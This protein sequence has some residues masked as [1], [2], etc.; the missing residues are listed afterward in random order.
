MKHVE[1]DRPDFGSF[2]P[3]GLMK[4]L[5]A[6]TRRCSPSW[7]G[8]RCAY[9]LRG[10]ALKLFRARPFD[11]FAINMKMR[12]YPY[13][14]TCEKRLLFMPQYFD[15]DELAYLAERICDDFV[16]IDIGANVGAYALYV[17]S[18]A[19]QRARILAVEPQPAIFERLVYNI[20]E[21]AFQ[22]VKAIDCAVADRPGEVTFFISP[23]NH[24]ES[25]MK[26][27]QADAHESSIR[28][29]AKTLQQLIEDE[30]FDHVDV[31]KIDAEGA[32]DLILES[33][34]GGASRSLWPKLMI[35]EHNPTDWSFDVEALLVE[36]GYR[37]VFR[38]RANRG[39][40]L[41]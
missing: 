35:L 6:A 38:T 2:A 17:A 4:L 33:F 7:S 5:I 18:L 34:F 15:A 28:V 12:I 39:W 37:E 21:N 8:Q 32:E 30:R 10:L 26:L 40:E 1:T 9:L 16:F 29:N 41:G 36:S 19:G 27:V 3:R 25:S 31:V 13:N 14:N 24:G 23:R 11:I 20:R 22:S